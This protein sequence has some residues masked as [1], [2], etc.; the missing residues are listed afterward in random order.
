M[1]NKKPNAFKA[2]VKKNPD[3]VPPTYHAIRPGSIQPEDIMTEITIT[4]KEL[5]TAH[6]PVSGFHKPV[7]KIIAPHEKK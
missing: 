4:K 6:F 7:S 2:I 3:K 5:G 1:K